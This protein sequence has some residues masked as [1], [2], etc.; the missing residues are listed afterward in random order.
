M[1]GIYFKTTFFSYFLWIFAGYLELAELLQLEWE[2]KRKSG[3]QE[4]LSIS[5]C[6]VLIVEHLWKSEWK[7]WLKKF[8]INFNFLNTDT[9]DTSLLMIPRSPR[10]K[11]E[12]CILQLFIR[13][14]PLRFPW[15]LSSLL[16]SHVTQQLFIFIPGYFSIF[17][18]IIFNQS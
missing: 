8:I 13:D 5:L 16:A 2:M 11:R 9:T 4:I 1:F 12:N 15:V 18:N 10:I 17:C 3:H 6:F 14:S 7:R